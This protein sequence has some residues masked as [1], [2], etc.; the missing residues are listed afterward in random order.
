MPLTPVS[1]SKRAMMIPSDGC[2]GGGG[3]ELVVDDFVGGVDFVVGVVWD[4][5][6]LDMDPKSP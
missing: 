4:V 3:E 1:I 2:G 5:G 6:E